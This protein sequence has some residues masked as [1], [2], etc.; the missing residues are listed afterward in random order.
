MQ[1]EPKNH[2]GPEDG[3]A[4]SA[5][6]R[7]SPQAFRDRLRRLRA[8]PLKR[9]LPMLLLELD[10]LLMAAMDADDRLD[11]ME[12]IKK[13][14]LKAAASLPKPTPGSRTAMRSADG[15]MTLEQRLIQLMIANLRQALHDYDRAQGSRLLE[16]DDRRIWLLHQIFRFFGRQ[17]RY[18]IDWDRT[19]PQ[20]TW[21]DLHDLFVYLVVRGS[22]PLDSCF[23]VAVFDDEFDAAIEYKRL[24]LLGLVDELTHR[25]GPTDTY[26]HWLKRWAVD[27]R[28]VEPEKAR[29]RDNVVQVEVTMDMPPHV[30]RGQLETSFRGWVLQPADGCL[31]YVAQQ[32]QARR[33]G[34]AGAVRHDACRAG[35]TS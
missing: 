33:P 31:S 13:P 5:G 17:L 10:R 34:G 14:V 23:T 22:V 26:F 11:L 25:A 15:G 20:H 6:A 28:L 19:L 1:Q 18:A 29:G 7:T 8:L 16:D 24:L 27:S 12:A 30:H 32:R 35:A 2:R 21:Q 9:A 4:Q 3:S